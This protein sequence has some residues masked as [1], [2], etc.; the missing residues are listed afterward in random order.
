[1]VYVTI[2]IPRNLY[3]EM[4]IYRTK[5]GLK[6]S[7]FTRIALSEFIEALKKE[8]VEK[9]VQL[10]FAEFYMQIATKHKDLIE[11]IRRERNKGRVFK[12]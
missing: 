11:K 4:E 8:E 9:Y 6:R 1:M 2:W 3:E 7:E 5:L 12:K 10:V